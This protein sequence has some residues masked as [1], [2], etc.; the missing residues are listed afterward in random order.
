MKPQIEKAPGLI[1]RTKGEGWEAIWRARDD[2]IK[3]G[4][5]P[6]NVPMWS[7]TGEPTLTECA[8]IQDRC[9]SLQDEMLLFGRTNGENLP[10][11]NPFDGTLKSLI[12][13]YQTDPDSPFLKRRFHVR[14]NTAMTLRRMVDRHGDQELSEIKGRLL[15][16]WHKD[17][18][19]N[20]QKLAMGHAV[21][22]HLRSL[23]S[24]GATFLEDE[25]C[26]RL[27]GVLHR[28][29]F[30]SPK[31]RNERLTA[32]QAVAIRK[33]ARE[34]FGWESI[35]LAQALQFELMLRQKDVIG[36]W[37]PV[38]EPG[39]SDVIRGT[40]KWLHGL[41][42]S[43]LNDNLIL[44]H[45]TSKRGKELVIDLKLSPMVLEELE[46][47]V[48]TRTASGPMI[49]CDTTGRPFVQAEFRR[50]WR[51]VADKAGVPRAVKNMDTR[52]GAISEATDGGAD[53]EH[54]RHA[55]THSNISMTQRYSRGSEDK[56][57]QVQRIRNEGRNKPKKTD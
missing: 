54:V 12:E 3:I 24:F 9:R 38:S 5:T 42:W 35:A 28:M 33:V 57:A 4:F 15:L 49:I 53:L 21:M 50:K 11:V 48:C 37:V 30:A 56:I 1:W 2:I 47:G 55:A 39:M 31:P 6:K 13:C 23:F 41:R 22:A 8:Q 36:E 26:E 32:E 20:G 45:V 43:E 29:R 10:K 7:G 51:L 19:D 18:S 40:D 27:C 34:H 46:F 25:N 52:S 16:A 17:W 14:Q 44:R